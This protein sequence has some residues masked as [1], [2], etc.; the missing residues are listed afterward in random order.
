MLFKAK[1]K[2]SA[3][4]IFH[5]SVQSTQEKHSALHVQQ[6]AKVLRRLAVNF[7]VLVS[8]KHFPRTMLIFP[9]LRLHTDHSAYIVHNI[10]LGAG[11]IRESTLDEIKIEYEVKY[12][13]VPFSKSVS[14]TFFAH[15]SFACN[16]RCN[17]DTKGK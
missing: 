5:I 10:E 17:T 3:R 6:A 15:F 16:N 8:W 1:K 12:Q 9:F 7:D 11:D 13:K 2:I 4:T 14:I